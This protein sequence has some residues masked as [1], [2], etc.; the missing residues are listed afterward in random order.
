MSNISATPLISI[1]TVTYNAELYLEVTIK[2]VIEQTYQ[3]IEYILIDGASKD[4]TVNI[5][6][7]YQEHIAYW[8]SE[9]DKGLYDAMNKGLRAAT[10]DY[11]LFL[12]A[13]D[14]LFASDTIQKCF[15]AKNAGAD[16]Y[17]GETMLI[18]EKGKSLGIRSETTRRKLPKN[19]TWQDMKDGM[20]VCHQSFIVRKNIAPNYIENNL[21]AD[22]DWVIYCLKSAKEIVHTDII[23]SNFL[24]GGV[25][26]QQQKKAWK[27]RFVVYKKHY[28]W[29]QNL[30]IHL[31]IVF[32]VIVFSFKKKEHKIY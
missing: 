23:I 22:I 14:L 11:V 28:G 21:C 5:I 32:K 30:W 17:Y 4:G 15:K 13:G 26:K 8:V 6:Q 19:M 18:D 12:N 10:G 9:P 24:V 2:S 1:V 25:S 29:F 7:Q 20:V 31:L 16:I 3:N 27:D